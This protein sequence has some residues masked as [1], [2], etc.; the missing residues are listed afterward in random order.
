[1]EDLM[2][3]F[4][5]LFTFILL[6]SLTFYFSFL[7]IEHRS[8]YNLSQTIWNCT[9]SVLINKTLPHEEECIE[10]SKIKKEIK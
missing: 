5:I 4:G 9:K 3:T 7:V 10:Y 8:N 6:I 1:M 2:K